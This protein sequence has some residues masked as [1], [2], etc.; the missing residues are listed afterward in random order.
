MYNAVVRLSC[1]SISAQVVLSGA[2]ISNLHSYDT[3]KLGIDKIYS[4]LGHVASNYLS[5]QLVLQYVLV[6]LVDTL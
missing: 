4:S 6:N 1:V 5:L 3:S 2:H